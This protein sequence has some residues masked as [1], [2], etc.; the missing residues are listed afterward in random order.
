MVG[1]GKKLLNGLAPLSA[2]PAAEAA[3]VVTVTFEVTFEVLVMVTVTLALGAGE[4]VRLVLRDIAQAYD[5]CFA[6]ESTQRTLD[7]IALKFA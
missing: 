3:E 4:S 7:A 1:L 2:L 6:S 5:S